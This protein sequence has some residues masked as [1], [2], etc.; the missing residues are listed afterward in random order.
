MGSSRALRNH[1][2][3][4][5]LLLV[6]VLILMYATA[7]LAHT[8][9]TGLAALIVTGSTLTYRLTL[10]LSELP[11][12]PARLFAAAVDGD[13]SSIERVATLLRQSLQIRTDDRLCRSGRATLQH[14]RLGDTRLT[15]EL[16]FYCPVVLTRRSYTM[17]GLTRWESI[18]IPWH[19]LKDRAVY[20]RLPSCQTCARLWWFLALLHHSTLPV[21][22]G[23]ESSIFSQGM[24]ICFFSWPFCC[25]GGDL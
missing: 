18:I 22:F 11:E 16:T 10:V 13:P 12:E 19:A 9:S 17:T 20:T 15:L 21:S 2:R 4:I 5:I 23:S 1:R 14:S 3:D 24:T 8:T 25:V 6:G 7:V